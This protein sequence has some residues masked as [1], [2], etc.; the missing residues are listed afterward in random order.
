MKLS[1]NVGLTWPEVGHLYSVGYKGWTVGKVWSAM[2]PQSGAI[3]WEWHLC[4]PMNLP[5]DAQG[6]A[7]SKS[8]ALQA[9]ADSLHGVILRT[10]S[11]RLQRA[12]LLAEA[13]GLTFDDGTT[14]EFDVDEPAALSAAAAPPALVLAPVRPLAIA[15][16]HP[17]VPS[18]GAQV[19]QPAA[20][21]AGRKRP[22]IKVKMTTRSGGA[23]QFAIPK[24]SATVEGNGQP[25][26]PL[27]T[28]QG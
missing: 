21:A 23:V 25:N 13:A 3:S 16:R 19:S 10:P 8:E 17:V 20:L 12:F 15:A 11:D 6:V 27:K 2:D 9:L 5:D 18:T 14:M 1:L 28:D 24:A 26:P 4:I 22:V 7:R